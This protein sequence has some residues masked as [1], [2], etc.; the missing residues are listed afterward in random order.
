MN[1]RRGCGRLCLA[2]TRSTC[3]MNDIRGGRVTSYMIDIRYSA[4]AE[5]RGDQVPGSS[6]LGQRPKGASWEIITPAIVLHSNGESAPPNHFSPSSVQLKSEINGAFLCK[7]HQQQH[8]EFCNAYLL[9]RG[10][11]VR[12][13]PSAPVF[14]CEFQHRPPFAKSTQTRTGYHR[15]STRPG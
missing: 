4:V 2:K 15:R 12:V 5:F 13:S 9:S 7:R 11:G 3:E 6:K 14:T 1:C 10:S 8:L